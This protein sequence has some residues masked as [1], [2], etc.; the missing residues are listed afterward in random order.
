M[1][2]AEIYSF[3]Y[4]IPMLLSAIFSLKAFTQKWPKPFKIF[5]V[6]LITVFIFEIFAISWSRGWFKSYFPQYNQSNLW[7]YNLDLII[8]YSILLVFFYY[9]VM[10]R[11]TRKIA[12]SILL[13]LAPFALINYF[14][15]QGPYAVNVYSLVFFQ[16]LSLV[17]G[18]IIFFQ[19]MLDDNTEKLI[20]KPLTWI[21][22]GIFVYNLFAINFICLISYW[23]T[24]YPSIAS[25]LFN[26]NDTINIISYSF[27]LIAF[28]C[29][30]HPKSPS[31]LSPY[32]VS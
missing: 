12:L 29:K 7:I 31:T 11:S 22:I 20:T 13:I 9:T 19:V 4:L 25:I 16:L 5:S 30:P 24:H 32:P 6:Y 2:L 1:S 28:L 8:A 10:N 23:S 27:F 21:L 26:A 15:W 14:F 3:I 18:T 17:L